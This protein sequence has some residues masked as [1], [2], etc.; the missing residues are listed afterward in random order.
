MDEDLTSVLRD[1]VQTFFLAHNR[2]WLDDDP[3]R[4]YLTVSQQFPLYLRPVVNKLSVLG[5]KG[6]GTNLQY[7]ILTYPNF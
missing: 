7:T 6:S 4:T 2:M 5:E 1:D 3:H